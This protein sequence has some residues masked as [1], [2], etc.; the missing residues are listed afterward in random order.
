M[1][2][3]QDSSERK[4]DDTAP[5]PVSAPDIRTLQA[6]LAGERD[7]YL[8]LAAD[9]DNFRKRSARETERRAA[10]QKEA[11]IRDL[12][13]VIDNLE[14]ALGSD[15]STS[16]QQLRQGVQMTLQQLTQLLRLHGVEPEES[17]GR[18]FNPLYHEAVS[19]RH[20]PSQP[21]CVILETFQ[22]GYRRGNEVFRPAK[23]VVN[24]LGDTGHTEDGNW[25]G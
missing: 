6:E 25:P 12:L 21:D 15:V 8:R 23:V 2:A 10:A 5:N 24:D 18:P 7:R 11:F 13:P 20:D 3:D 16:P 14:R 4:A 22:R 17:V 9:F 1:S 19:V